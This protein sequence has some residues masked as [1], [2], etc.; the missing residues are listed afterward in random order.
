[1][2]CWEHAHEHEQ[3]TKQKQKQ[4]KEKEK[5]KKSSLNKSVRRLL[6][7]TGP[8]VKLSSLYKVCVVCVFL[9]HMYT[10]TVPCIY[11]WSRPLNVVVY[12]K[13]STAKW[14]RSYYTYF[15]IFIC[16]FVFGKD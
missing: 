3:Q 1:M 7:N 6:P 13:L 15:F 10:Y 8:L 11:T 16:F 4:E 12:I 9:M 5:E 2:R 14:R